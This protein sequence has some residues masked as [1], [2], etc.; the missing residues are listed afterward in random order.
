MT[1]RTSCRLCAQEPSA[2]REHEYITT[3]SNVAIVSEVRRGPG[4]AE[5][6]RARE[7]E[8]EREARAAISFLL[9]GTERG[10]PG[11]ESKERYQVVAEGADYRLGIVVVG[12]AGHVSIELLVCVLKEDAP[13]DVAVLARVLR[14]AEALRSRGYALAHQGDGWISCD[15]SISWKGAA[16]ECR[17]LLGLLDENGFGQ[18]PAVGRRTEEE[19]VS[20]EV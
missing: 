18:S 4:G 9:E 15:R 13:L 7:D 2:V 20:K 11:T 10:A 3:P 16:R 5:T 6:K 8:I 19:N 14:M 17:T 12:P 1:E